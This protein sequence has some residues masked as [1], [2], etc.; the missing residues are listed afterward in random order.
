MKLIPVKAPNKYY[1]T[2][3]L[4]T[5]YS[6]CGITNLNQLCNICLDGLYNK[7]LGVNI[8]LTVQK[9]FIV[10]TRSESLKLYI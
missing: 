10:S 3:V 6:K 8:C 7:S 5:M 4:Y 9:D 2:T 1:S